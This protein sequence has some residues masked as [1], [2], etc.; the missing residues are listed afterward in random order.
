MGWRL[1]IG[2]CH[3]SA[4]LSEMKVQA[5]APAAGRSTGTSSKAYRHHKQELKHRS[6]K[7]HERRRPSTTRLEA[8]PQQSYMDGDVWWDGDIDPWTEAKT[9]VRCTIGCSNS[10]FART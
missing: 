5:F 4:L 10:E 9:R 3:A 2:L 7:S 6:S 8:T 1:S